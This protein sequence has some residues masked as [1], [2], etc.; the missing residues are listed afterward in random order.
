MSN[1]KTR[2]G[3]I[4]QEVP[5]EDKD[6]FCVGTRIEHM[7]NMAGTQSLA[8]LDSL[9]E[10]IHDSKKTLERLEMSI[11]Q[12][13]TALEQSMMD[14]FKVTLQNG[15]GELRDELTGELETVKSRLSDLEVKTRD[16][17]EQSQKQTVVIKN[18][19]CG[20]E[21]GAVTT[22]VNELLNDGL[23]LHNIEIE[24][25]VKKA[26]PR[27]GVEGMVF[28]KF[29]TEDDFRSVLRKKRFLKDKEPYSKVFIEPERSKQEQDAVTSLRSI[30]KAV[31]GDKLQVRGTRI[32]EK[33]SHGAQP[34]GN[35]RGGAHPRGGN[36]RGR[37][38]NQ[39]GRGGG[40]RVQSQDGPRNGSQGRN[41]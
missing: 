6:D 1:T 24:D 14:K 29:K 20:Q 9:M 37:G 8:T 22:K 33:T 28:V 26:S 38:G 16:T 41:S 35:N 25:V 27:E 17:P 4:L 11:N 30:V 40:Q 10:A 5:K 18:L 3:K 32:V 36:Q 15:I 7:P 21:H 13:F 19:A 39:G 23:E 31:G 2:S 12:R 34:R